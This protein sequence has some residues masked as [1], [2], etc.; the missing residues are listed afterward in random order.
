MTT[1][2]EVAGEA[3]AGAPIASG[4]ATEPVIGTG[5]ATLAI[6]A[7]GAG[8]H[9]VVGSGAAT[10]ALAAY[11][12]SSFFPI[13]IGNG[14]ASLLLSAAGVATY[15]S[16]GFDPTRRMNAGLTAP[17]GK[18]V[19]GDRSITGK[20]DPTRQLDVE[21]KIAW[22]KGA[23]IDA[24]RTYLWGAAKVI[25]VERTARW[26]RFE[27]RLDIEA[28]YPW[29][30]S[31]AIDEER[32]ARWGRFE[33]RLDVEARYPWNGSIA[34][35][36][37]TT[38]AWG[39][40][41][42]AVDVQITGP[43]ARSTVVDRSWLIPWGGRGR[44]LDPSWGV[45]TP[46]SVVEPTPGE[47]IIVPV[48]SVY[49]VINDTQLIRVDDNTLLPCLGMSMTL[50]SESWTWTFSASLPAGSIDAVQPDVDGAPVELDA[51]VNGSFFRM[52]VER[53]KRDRRFVEKSQSMMET[54][55]IAG[56]GTNLVL[57][58]PRAP[59]QTFGNPADARTAQQ[60]MGDVLMFNGVPIGWDVE[61]N[62][63]DWLV[64]AGA[65]S[66]RG[67]YASA[68]SA[69][70]KAAGGYLQPHA[71]Q[72]IVRVLPL[73][74]LAPWD[75]ATSVT[76]DYELPPDVV[77]IESIEWQ[78]KPLYNRVFI[79]GGSQGILGLVT[80]AGTAGDLVAPMIVDALNT[81]V[82]ASRQRGTAVLSDTGR[83]AR[84]GLRMPVLEMTGV[85]TPGRF[86]RYLD[87]TGTRLGIVR[88]TSVEVGEVEAWQTLGVE[89]HV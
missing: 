4:E 31:K 36:R 18:S 84:V 89:T 69:I 35:N 50:D 51:Y 82:D 8:A 73:Y 10:L 14:N 33:R 85:I 11:G 74:P 61:W 24:E 83:Q 54:I 68:L 28:R 43:F 58:T 56:R 41:M 49:M 42:R 25:D 2:G 59:T 65:W 78:D 60:L 22:G 39:G 86:V 72:Q 81:H 29:N 77:T 16:L 40:P 75:W 34:R 3:I 15:R 70:A 21:K 30:G 88:S 32:T 37:E 79:S 63:T 6:T 23:A 5:S 13:I 47:T 87:D 45:V 48:R 66:H 20:Y 38:V 44:P 7:V 76:P 80:R 9:G 62:L 67:G 46:P 19:A 26:G 57:D 53:I 17:W 1:H 71:Y 52:R 27:R 12:T 55:S 64:P